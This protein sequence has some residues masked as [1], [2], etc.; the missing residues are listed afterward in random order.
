MLVVVVVMVILVILGQQL[1][2][3]VG[4][5]VGAEVLPPTIMGQITLVAVAVEIVVA[6]VMVLSL[7]LIQMTTMI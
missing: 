4:L 1:K 6:V 7:S 3:L 2:A 5:A